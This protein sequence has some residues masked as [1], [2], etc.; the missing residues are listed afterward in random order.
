MVTQDELRDRIGRRP[1]QAFRVTLTTGEAV[2]VTRTQQ[3]VA[4]RR[5]LIVGTNDDQFRWI[6]LEQISSV[7]PITSPQA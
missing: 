7:D 5:R 1:F 2:D 3:A 6:W 4:M